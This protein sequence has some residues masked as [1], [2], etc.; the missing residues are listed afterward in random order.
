MVVLTTA[1]VGWY[2]PYT[3]LSG[4]RLVADLLSE[5]SSATGGGRFDGLCPAV[6]GDIPRLIGLLGIAIVIKALLYV[7]CG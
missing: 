4:T 3:R 5:C 1:T 6:V 7:G 2:N